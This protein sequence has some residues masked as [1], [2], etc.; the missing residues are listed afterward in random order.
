MIRRW[1]AGRRRALVCRDAVALMSDYVDDVL[2]ERDRKRLD[3]HL[4]GCPLCTEFLAQLRATIDAL[5]H[6]E[7]DDLSDA[8]LDEFVALYRQWRAG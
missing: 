2:D 4:A 6:A 1:L 7:P 3:L 5:G 8:A